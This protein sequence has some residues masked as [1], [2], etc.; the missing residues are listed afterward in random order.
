MAL[1]DQVFKQLRLVVQKL[2]SNVV[3]AHLVLNDLKS[4]ELPYKLTKA[5]TSADALIAGPWQYF[6]LF[7]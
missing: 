1:F 7:L 4:H 2:N 5:S 3:N 6:N